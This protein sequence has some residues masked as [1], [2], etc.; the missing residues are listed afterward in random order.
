QNFLAGILLLLTEPFRIGD[1]ILVGTFEG[2]VEEIQTRATLIRTYDGRRVVIPNANLFTQ[3]VTVNT[4]FDSRRSEYNIEISHEVDI[5]RIKEQVLKAISSIDDVLKN[6]PP[7]ALAVNITSTSVTLRVRWWA[8]LSGRKDVL[9]TQDKV[10]LA[11]K[12]AL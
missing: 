2:T 4:A 5:E 10:I 9:L 7:D 1:Q 3:S 11:I 6:P 12:K 8:K